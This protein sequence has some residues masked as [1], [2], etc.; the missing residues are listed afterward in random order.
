MAG[1]TWETLPMSVEPPRTGGPDR[2]RPR[3]GQVGV[4]QRG[5][6]VVGAYRGVELLVGAQVQ[7]HPVAMARALEAGRTRCFRS[8][9]TPM[10]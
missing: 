2:V 10:S 7:V 3:R 8:R 1:T 4:P 9:H 5:E 6:G